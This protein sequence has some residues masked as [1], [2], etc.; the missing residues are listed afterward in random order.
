MTEAR[1]DYDRAL[2][3]DPGLAAAALNRGILHYHEHRYG[4]AARDLHRALD[5]G[6][7]PAMAWYNLALVHVAQND[8]AEA[9]DAVQRALRFQPEAKDAVELRDRLRTTR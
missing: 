6:A 8:R 4:E 2:E 5:N 1:A 7:D 9:L 3:L